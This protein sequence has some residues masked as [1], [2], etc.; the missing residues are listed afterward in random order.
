MSLFGIPACFIVLIVSPTCTLSNYQD[1]PFDIQDGNSGHLN[2][3][4][5]TVE[6]VVTVDPDNEAATDDKRC[7]PKSDRGRNS[8][9]PCKTLEY[10]FQQFH[11]VDSVMFF[12]AS[13]SSDY[14]LQTVT[15]FKHVNEISIVGNSSTNQPVE[16]QCEPHAGLSFLNSSTITI[17]NVRFLHCGAP[18]NSTSRNFTNPLKMQMLMINVSLYFYNCTDIVLYRVEVINSSQATGVVMYDTNGRVQVKSCFFINNT[19]DDGIPGGGG[20]A[21][22]FTYCSPGDTLCSN[23]Y[24]QYYPT[25]RRKT[26]AA[27]YVFTDCHFEGNVARGQSITS[28]AGKLMLASLANHVAV[29]RGGGLAV[30]IKGDA[31]NKSVNISACHFI[32]NGAVW[33]GGLIVETDD[34]TISNKILISQCNI[35]SNYAFFHDDHGTGGG[36]IRVATTIYFWN[37]TYRELN[38]TRNE[39]LVEHSNFIDNKAIEGGAVSFS[40]ARQRLSYFSQVTYLL[41]SDCLFNSNKAQLGAAVGVFFYP[42]FSQGIIASVTFHSCSFSNNHIVDHMYD[43]ERDDPL[44][45]HPSGMGAV[46]TNEVSAT[47]SDLINFSNNRGTALCVVAAQ[48]DFSGTDAVFYN[49]SGTNGGG[50]AL[51]GAS[52]I[53]TGP[54]TTMTFNENHASVYGGAI[55]IRY[56]S[57]ENLKSNV[58]CFVRYSDPFTVPFDWDVHFNFSKNMAEKLGNSIYSTAVLPCSW[59]VLSTSSF[60]SIFCNDSEHWHYEESNCIDEIFT[61][62]QKIKLKNISSPIK[63]FPG[64]GF[65]LPLDA[66]D[67]F[68]HRVTDD[69]V[70]VADIK[71]ST[72]EVE[73]GFTYVANN[74]VQITGEPATNVTMT[75]YTAGSRNTFIKVNLSIQHCPPGFIQYIP[76]VGTSANDSEAEDDYW[77]I[78]D[79][80]TTDDSNFKKNISCKCPDSEIAFRGNLRCIYNELHSQVHKQYWIGSPQSSDGDTFSE[81][82]MG[83]VP[84]Y[85]TAKA[86]YGDEFIDLPQDINSIDSSICGRSS[87]T[88]ILCGQCRQGHAVAINSRTYECVPCNNTDVVKRVGYICAYIALTYL[89]ILCLFLAII[90]FNIK[91]TSSAAFSFVLFAQM[92]GSEVFSLTA[93]KAVYLNNTKI[94]RMETAYTTV[95]GLFNLNSFSFLMKPF[96][97]NKHLTALDVL[98]LEYAM[99]AF[100]LVMIAAIHLTYRCSAIRCRCYRRK[101]QQQL[102][103]SN[104]NTLQTNGAPKESEKRAPRNS[105]IHAFVAFLFLSYTKFSLASMFTMSNTELFNATGD[106]CGSYI[107]Y[108]AG[109][110][111]FSHREYLLPYG[112]LAILVV[113]F[114]VTLPVLLLLGPIQFI[115]WLIDKRGFGCLRKVWPSIIIHTFLDSFQSSYKPN[116]RFFSGVYF[117]FRLAVFFNYTFS[118][119]IISKYVFQQVALMVLIGLVALFRPY[120]GEFYNYLDII[121]LSNLGVLNALAIYIYSSK[122]SA[123]PYKVYTVACVLVW[124]PLMYIICYVVWNQVH[125]RKHYNTVKEKFIRLVNPVKSLQETGTIEECEQLLRPDKSQEESSTDDPDERLFR[126]AARRNRYTRGIQNWRPGAVSTTV[127]RTTETPDEVER[128]L[129]KRDSGT[130]TGGSSRSG[131]DSNDS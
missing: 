109:H 79:D 47:F 22:E 120:T 57:K 116:R 16:I 82:L 69:T 88:G 65:E 85:Y 97:I 46:Y 14:S 3:H 86:W 60:N 91:L 87:R 36:G 90:F 83:L 58:N 121:I 6:I 27:E 104:P 17:S 100:P 40:V 48:V 20:F 32:N 19:A 72:A 118:R 9:V 45:S 128:D 66:F 54:G 98:A 122:S 23:N 13:P 10:A 21:V 106:S 114:V 71:N 59:G 63:V 18:Q 115:D 31:V 95:Y 1:N 28:V 61:E 30:F 74:Y 37:T 92:I 127:V 12:L 41:L 68:N 55:Y 111:R 112:I 125:K 64:R 131:L 50:I 62:P 84:D 56:I 39:I 5:N 94:M 11:D 2:S 110:L 78:D 77:S 89:P 67:D 51:L 70:Y 101:N 49:N 38:Y 102:H 108:Y 119:D 129:V 73:P 75:M 81:L 107:I 34:S 44:D 123:F 80:V 76:T 35:T 24:T 126:C 26:V 130:S 124:L 29:G 52:S 7:H 53:L 96:C 103:P 117:L 15:T 25:Y 113:I 8:S 105:L 93:G 42:I 99:A 33:G 43:N 4:Y